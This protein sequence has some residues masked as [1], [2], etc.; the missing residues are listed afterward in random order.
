MI[1]EQSVT[2]KLDQ[3]NHRGQAALWSRRIL[4]QTDVSWWHGCGGACC[5]SF[6]WCKTSFLLPHGSGGN[7]RRRPHKQGLGKALPNKFPAGA[8]GAE[9]EFWYCGRNLLLET[10]AF[11]CVRLS[12]IPLVPQTGTVPTLR[13]QYFPFHS[14]QTTKERKWRTFRQKLFRQLIL[15]RQ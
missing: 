10:A 12:S 3:Y 11:C 14:L 4:H 2:K 5:I 6:A 9:S 13:R 15:S 7:G 8:K 1:S